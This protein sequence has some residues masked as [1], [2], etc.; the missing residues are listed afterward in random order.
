MLMVA[1]LLARRGEELSLA[2]LAGARGCSRP[3]RQCRIQK[4]GLALAGD[5]RCLRP[6]RVHVLGQTESDFLQTLGPVER[7]ERLAM[8]C[9][10]P[11]ACL[12]VTKGLPVPP[13][14]AE[15]AEREGLPL[16]R[17]PLASHLLISRVAEFLE[18]VLAEEKA[19]HGSLVDVFGVGILLQGKSGIGKSE[20]ALALVE[21]GHRLVAD[22]LVA[23]RKGPFGALVG[24][25]EPAIA[26]HMEIRGL[27]IINIKDL[28]GVS[29]TR[30]HKRIGLVINLVEWT[31][32]MAVERVGLEEHEW[33][34]MGV[35]LPRHDIPVRPGRDLALIVE[36]AARNRLL[37]AQGYHSA[38]DLAEA[39]APQDA[40]AAEDVDRGDRGEEE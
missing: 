19:V 12:I 38:R 17:S 9:R 33:M 28:Y 6:D 21:R 16:L 22:D 2:L 39:L 15:A 26:D 11:I 7:R 18:E 27:G 30:P 23:V 36:V 25:P 13:E 29:S 31:T 8:A 10:A 34:L 3:I 4:L 37:R 32:G 35:S 20:C 5:I 1:D 14:L 40:R 24:F